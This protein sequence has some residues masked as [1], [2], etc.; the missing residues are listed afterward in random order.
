[1]FRNAF[2]IVGL[3]FVFGCKQ[4]QNHEIAELSAE[5]IVN[6]SI[7]A[8]GGDVF[9]HSTIDFDFRDMHYKAVRKNGS[10]RLERQFKK[11]N[12]EI[13]DVLSNS[14]FERF[15]DDEKVQVSDSLASLYS[16]SVNSVHYFSVLPNGLND[17][18]VHKKSLGTVNIEGKD[19]YKIKVTFSEDGGGED[20]DDV[21]IYWINKT[22]FNVDYL[23]YSFKEKDGLGYRFRKA[24]NARV[25]NGLRFVDYNN[26][27][28][29]NSVLK[30]EDLDDLF[31]ANKLQLLSNIE[32]RNIKVEVLN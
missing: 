6:Q 17:K 16:A 31:M 30:I 22:S 5:E 7:E 28:P 24:Y 32:L 25:V 18:A 21:F 27:L 12:S 4:K 14:G 2:F 3:L 20:F 15:E 19:Y 1:M 9:K 10:F 26:Y 13:R 23:A 29:E 11:A 8:A